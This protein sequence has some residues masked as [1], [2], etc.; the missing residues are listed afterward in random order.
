MYNLLI[1]KMK[2]VNSDPVE[3]YFYI[4]DVWKS[5]NE[6]IGK[7]LSFV[8]SGNVFCFCGK[9]KKKFYRQNFC[10]DCFWSLPQASPSIFKPEL[11]QAH[12]GIEERDLEWEKKFQLQPHVVYL[13]VSSG[14]KVG[15]TRKNSIETRWIDQGA[16]SGIILAETPNR[17]LAGKLEV[18]LKQY[19]TDK[20][21]WTKM[22]KGDIVN[23]DLI[24]KKNEVFKLVDNEF[25]SYM[26]KENVIK[27][28]NFPLNHLP[29]KIKSI[30]LEK[31]NII[32]EKLVGIKGQYLIFEND[33]VFNVRR[34]TGYKVEFSIS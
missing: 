10:Y 18:H 16:I 25:K 28:I 30:S 26:I 23:V 29:K 7:K 1:D 9:K 3:Y 32:N 27:K 21:S 13:S 19:F 12:L 8:W 14:L 22:L 34:H 15:V 31:Q 24:E 33:F 4:N 5:V 20:T 17:Y 6:L 11:C 2:V